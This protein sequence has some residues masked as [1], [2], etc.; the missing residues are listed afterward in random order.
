MKDAIYALPDQEKPATINGEDSGPSRDE[1]LAGKSKYDPAE[2]F[3]RTSPITEP[4]A[5]TLTTPEYQ[6]KLLQ[7]SSTA[8][9][10]LGYF[11]PADYSNAV[12]GRYYGSVR[13]VVNVRLMYILNLQILT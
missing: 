2:G 6:P 5:S 7:F 12:I 4:K 10:L 8:N 9:E 11:I 3:L 1:A 13:R